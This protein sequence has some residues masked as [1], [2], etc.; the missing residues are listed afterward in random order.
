MIILDSSPLIHLT[1]IGKID[2]LINLFDFIIISKAVY[3]EVI[4][5]GE[6][7]GYSDARLLLN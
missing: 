2:Y 4:I 3:K 7:A 5:K 1:K 6:K